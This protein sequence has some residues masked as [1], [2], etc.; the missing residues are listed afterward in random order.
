MN[1]FLLLSVAC[2]VVLAATTGFGELR[3]YRV[4]AGV[5]YWKALEDLKDE[6]PDVDEDGMAW[7]ILYEIVP[8]SLLKFELDLEVFPEGFGGYLDEAVYSPQ[9][10]I[11]FG[12]S[13]YIGAGGGTVYADGEWGDAFFALRAGVEFEL[14]QHLFLDIHA[15]YLMGTWEQTV[16][17]VEDPASIDVNSLTLGG[18]IKVAF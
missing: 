7:L 6:L 4:G 18:T 10:Y 8:T 14:I 1:R 17:T 15:N 16:E 11:L 3:T 5:H 12:P 13:L 2:V 9:G